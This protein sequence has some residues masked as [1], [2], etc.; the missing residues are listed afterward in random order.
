[1]TRLASYTTGGRTR[2]GLLVGTDLLDASAAWAVALAASGVPHAEMRAEYELPASMLAFLETG[3]IAR[4]ALAKVSEFAESTGSEE[5]ARLGLLTPIDDA[6][7]QVPIANP[8]KIVCV[9]RNYATHAKEAN[10]PLSEIP[11]LFARFASTLI[12]D[13]APILIPTLSDQ[14]DWEGE[15]AVII[16][17]GGRHIPRE[18]ALEHVAGYS[19]FNDVSVRDYQFRVSQY[20]EGKNFA[21]SGPFGPYLVLADEVPDPHGLSIQTRVNGEIMQEGNTSEMVFD[22]P[23]IVSHISE[24][25]D[26]QAGDVIPMGTPAGVGFTRT[27][28]IFL[29]EGDRIEVEITGLGTLG[30]PVRKE[31]KA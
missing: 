13:G 17:R 29:R 31:E 24:F 14:V 30:N 26:L 4:D 23:T 2:L 10:R 19:I 25:I 22:V 12:P 15:L 8:P 7:L 1:M 21:S 3:T 5:L 28:P 6:I 11:I 27:P 16:G 18:R 9:A 20:T